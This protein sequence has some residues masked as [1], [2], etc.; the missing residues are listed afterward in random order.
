[1]TELRLHYF[2]SVAHATI[3]ISPLTLLVGTNSSGKS[4]V[5]QALLALTQAAQSSPPGGTFPL[6]GEIIRLGK[7]DSTKTLGSDKDE[8]LGIGI[9]LTTGEPASDFSS[10]PF[11]MRRMLMNSSTDDALQFRW[12]IHLASGVADQPGSARIGTVCLSTEGATT[13]RVELSVDASSPAARLT[14]SG[15]DI[16]PGRLSSDSDDVGV[17]LAGGLPTRLT[18]KRAARE[19]VDFWMRIYIAM[20][21]PTHRGR[22]PSEV[23]VDQVAEAA[24]R[25]IEEFLSQA[26]DVIDLQDLAVFVRRRRLNSPL[27]IQETVDIDILAD[28]IAELAE[29]RVA[30]LNDELRYGVDSAEGDIVMLAQQAI[31]QFFRGGVRHLGGLR[32]EPL[33]AM[34]SS[35]SARAGELGSKGEYTAAVLLALG[36]QLVTR[37]PALPGNPRRPSPGRLKPATTRWMQEL[38]LLS[39]VEAGEL[40]EF[41]HTIEVGLPGLED[42]VK[43]PAVGVGV[44]QVLPVVVACLLA[45]PGTIILLEQPELHLHPKAQQQLADFL[46]ACARTGRQLIVETHSEHLIN[47]LRLRVAAEDSDEVRDLVGIVFAE[48]DRESGFTSYRE[49]EVNEYGGYDEW[50]DGFFDQS[51]TE[52]QDILRAGLAKQYLHDDT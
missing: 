47:R 18:R 25:D 30:N 42:R 41:G 39:D 28:R 23:G 7:F 33:F 16:Y 9:T 26:H 3:P 12:E 45:D 38:D 27:P 29:S 44:S 6:N 37:P 17:F 52:L 32:A 36:D 5:L 49:V 46:I 35:A 22:H 34:P 31:S 4:S 13:E 19:L 15:K 40:A 21:M 51:I 1:M 14:D 48:R 43:L 2:K 20:P 11:G 10:G 8:G 50:P 24:V